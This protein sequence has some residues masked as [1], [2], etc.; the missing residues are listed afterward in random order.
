MK[1]TADP[2]ASMDNILLDLQISSYPTQPHSVSANYYTLNSLTIF[3]FSESSGFSKSAPV[4][5]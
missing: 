3:W 2:T 5:L 1:N 4:T